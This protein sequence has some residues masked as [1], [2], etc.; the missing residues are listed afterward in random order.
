MTTLGWSPE[1]QAKAVVR[2]SVDW[3][4]T[5]AEFMLGRRAED[6]GQK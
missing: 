6:Q 3:Q 2:S 5:V 4:A 1:V